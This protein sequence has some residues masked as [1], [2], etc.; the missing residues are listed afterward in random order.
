MT[1][2][3][4]P[5]TNGLTERFNKTLADMLSMYVR[6]E[7]KDSDEILPFVTFA[8]NTAKQDTT[9]FTPFYLI[10]GPDTETTLDIMFQIF[11]EETEG[12]YSARL[13]SRAEESRQLARLRILEAQERDRKRYDDSKHRIMYYKPGDLVRIFTPM[14]RPVREVA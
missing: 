6:V 14:R 10:H 3:Y 11:P 12:D 5:Q 8:Y 2:A 7:Q 4:H 9:G 13:V 1:T